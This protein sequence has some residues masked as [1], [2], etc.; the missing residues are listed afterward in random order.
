MLLSKSIAG[1]GLALVLTAVASSAV[2]AAPDTSQ[3]PTRLA[4][5]TPPP[6]GQRT[7]GKRGDML[8]QLNL[9]D[10]QKKQMSAIRQK[11]KGQM[12]TLRGDM[13]S[14]Q[15][16]LAQLMAGSG[17][18]SAIRAQHQKVEGLRDKLSALRFESMLEMRKVMTPEQRTQF[19]QMIHAQRG[20]HRGPSGGPGNGPGN[21]PDNGPDNGS[22]GFPPPAP[23]GGDEF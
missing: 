17:S 16:K 19:Q 5:A 18:D 14:A 22:G 21:G 11:Y 3:P 23:G 20:H 9:T 2:V 1:L 6:S 7:R 13:R 10:A 15:D 8:Q 4:Q 12:Q